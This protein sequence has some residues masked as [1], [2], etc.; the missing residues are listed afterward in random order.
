MLFGGAALAGGAVGPLRDDTAAPEPHGGDMAAMP[1]PP[2]RG[3][4]VSED[5]LTLPILASA[6][7]ALSSVSVVANALRLRRFRA[8]QGG[9]AARCH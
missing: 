9:A 1:A 8:A 4:A 5:G 2:V 6:A 7:M 3:L